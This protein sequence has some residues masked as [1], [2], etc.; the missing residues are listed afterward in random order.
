MTRL[1]KGEISYFAFDQP[2]LFLDTVKN[3]CDLFI[4][5]TYLDLIYLSPGT[6]GFLGCVSSAIGI[7]LLIYPELKLKFA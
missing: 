3:V 4:Q 2:A 6:V 5:M 1:T 7:Y